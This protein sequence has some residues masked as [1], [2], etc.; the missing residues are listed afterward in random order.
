MNLIV[1]TVL[2]LIRLWACSAVPGFVLAAE[3][4]G[5]FFSQYQE[6][7]KKIRK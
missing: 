3:L 2:I 1:R 6:R 7:H 4:I 5:R